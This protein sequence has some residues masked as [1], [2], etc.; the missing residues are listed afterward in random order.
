MPRS[1]DTIFA[2]YTG[3]KGPNGERS[4]Q[5]VELHAILTHI[6]HPSYHT[7]RTSTCCCKMQ[8]HGVIISTCCQEIAYKTCWREN[9]N[10]EHAVRNN[11]TVCCVV[12]P[13]CHNLAQHVVWVARVIN[14]AHGCN[15]MSAIW[16]VCRDDVTIQHAVKGYLTVRWTDVPHYYTSAQHVVIA[17]RVISRA[18]SYD[19]MWDFLTVWREK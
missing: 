14:I 9:P 5:H 4:C 19:S 18:Q 11:V 15:S 8:Q 1:V 3:R 13:C 6:V 10:I 7:V 2:S 12:V 17:A 16:T